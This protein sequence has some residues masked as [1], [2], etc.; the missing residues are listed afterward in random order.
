[1]VV[2]GDV[3]SIERWGPVCRGFGVLFVDGRRGFVEEIRVGKNGVELLAS[4]SGL[5]APRVVRIRPR[6]IEAIL[7]RARRIVLARACEGDGTENG[8]AVAVAGG[9]VRMAARRPPW[10]GLPPDEAA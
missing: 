7:P 8:V 4:S 2:T 10:A 9:L 6:E 1:M 5:F 3:S